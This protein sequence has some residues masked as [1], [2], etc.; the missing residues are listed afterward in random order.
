MEAPVALNEPDT[1][2]LNPRQRELF[3]ML[4]GVSFSVDVLT[5]KGVPVS[6]AVSTLTV[7][8]IYGLVRSIPGGM[9][10]KK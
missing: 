7:L 5:A 9:F 3:D 6:E 10:E 8:E 2:A 4:P 1:S